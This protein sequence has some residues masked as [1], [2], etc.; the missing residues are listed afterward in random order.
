VSFGAKPLSTGGRRSRP[1]QWRT[2]AVATDMVAG[3]S[4]G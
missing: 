3:I 1:G 4:F 2:G